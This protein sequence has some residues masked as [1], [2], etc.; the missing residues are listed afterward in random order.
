MKPSV[1]DGNNN[2]D[3]FLNSSTGELRTFRQLDREQ[4][5]LYQLRVVATDHGQPPRSNEAVVDITVLDWNDNNPEFE[6][7]FYTANIT[8]E[9]SRLVT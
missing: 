4:T 8:E 2:G 9:L 1:L 5:G 6:R 7:E 3:F